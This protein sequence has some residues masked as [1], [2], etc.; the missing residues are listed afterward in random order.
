[1][2]TS[3]LPV[4][5]ARWKPAQ[6]WWGRGLNGQPMEIDLVAEDLEGEALLLGEAKWRE[7]PDQGVVFERLRYCAENFP[8]ARERKVILG[9]WLKQIGNEARPGEFVVDPETTLPVLR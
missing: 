5:E 1:M 7:R 2:S 8:R 4:G 9:A 6:R 3:S